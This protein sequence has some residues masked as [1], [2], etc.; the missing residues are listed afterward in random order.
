MNRGTRVQILASI[1]M[2]LALGASS[3]FA[4]SMAG[5]TG[6]YKLVYTTRAE[7]AASWEVSAGIAMGAFRGIFVNWLWIRANDLK[8]AGKFHE[9][10]DLA[11]AIT[12]LQPRFPRVW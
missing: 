9:A 11:N 12:K 6:R 2:L 4:V 7:D 5:L 1:V 3:V 8:E 10:N